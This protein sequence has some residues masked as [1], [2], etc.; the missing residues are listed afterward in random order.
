MASDLSTTYHTRGGWIYLDWSG[1]GYTVAPHIARY[2]VRVLE[3]P[4]TGTRSVE[5]EVNELADPSAATRWVAAL[6]D[7]AR[8]GLE[9]YIL[10]CTERIICLNQSLRKEATDAE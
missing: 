3:C 10:Y 7:C 6:G 5:C 4:K 8:W 9:T 1:G 2:R